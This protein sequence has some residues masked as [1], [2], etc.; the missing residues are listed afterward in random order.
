MSNNFLNS[1]SVIKNINNDSPNYFQNKLHSS[2]LKNKTDNLTRKSSLFDSENITLSIRKRKRNLSAQTINYSKLQFL[3]DYIDKENE[4]EDEHLTSELFKS[5]KIDELIGSLFTLFSVGSGIVYYEARIC[6]EECLEYRETQ[7]DVINVCLVSCSIGIFGYLIS[8]IAKF[9]HYFKLYRCAR[10]INLKR[11]FYETNLLKYF[12]IDFFFAIIHPNLLFKNNFFKTGK[13]WNLVKIEYCVNDFLLVILILRLFYLAKAFILWSKFYDS[14]A[15]R[16]CKMMG[17]ELSLFFGIKCYMIHQPF[18]FIL[19]IL[20][21]YCFGLG[22]TLKIIEGPLLE[23]RI[24]E[25]KNSGDYSKFLNC[26]WNILVTMTTVGYGD[27]YPKSFLGRV[28]MFFIAISGPLLIGIIVNEFQ[29]ATQLS[30]YEKKA[31]D[32]LLRLKEREDIREKAASYFK[33]NFTYVIYKR[34][35]NREEIPINDET[36]ATMLSLAKEKFQKRKEFKK[37]VHVYGVKYKMGEDYD[38]INKKIEKLDENMIK[39]TEKFQ[40]INN[41]I[42]NLAF[43]IS[44]YIDN[45]E[46]L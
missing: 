30:V 20:L 16:I 24:S 41:K 13:N 4:L 21:I 29:N 19:F 38:K 14:R 39:L 17:K 32:F 6:N 15:D 31:F 25:N 10:Y 45:I 33:A 5:I 27:Y 28:I 42:N 40:I 26:I 7:N 18:L 36:K 37:S 3:Y 9:F 34:K 8:M 44:N 1:N 23:N 22:Y 11:K 35:L 46:N 2:D 12:I 43:N